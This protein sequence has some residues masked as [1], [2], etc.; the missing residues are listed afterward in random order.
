MEISSVTPYSQ[1]YTAYGKKAESVPPQEQAQ[2]EEAAAVYVKSEP[3]SKKVYKRDAETIRSLKRDME[4]HRNQ[5]RE[6]VVKMLRKQGLRAQDVL[7]GVAFSVDEETRLAAQKEIGENGYW[8]VKQTSERIVNFAK[9]LA[10]GDPSKAGAMR[11]AIKKGF[12]EAEKAWG[13]ALPDI[14]QQTYDA[15]MKE[16]DKWEKGE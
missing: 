16:L 4:A 5:L 7:N 9:T 3:E 1:A 13:G 6:M 10:G 2:E 15:V 14:C 8:G 12:E 11:D